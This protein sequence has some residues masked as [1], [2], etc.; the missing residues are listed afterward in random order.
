MIRTFCYELKLDGIR[1]IASMCDGKLQL[2]NKRG[3]RLLQRFPELDD[4]GAQI[5]TDCILDGEL[6]VFKDGI[7]DFTEIQKRMM[8][9][10]PF[11]IKLAAGKH[12]AVF[13]AFDILCVEDEQLMRRP[14]MER[15]Q[16][17]SEMIM[18]NTRINVSRFRRGIWRL[19]VFADGRD[20]ARR[21][22]RQT[23]DEPV[24]SGASDQRVDQVQEP[25]RR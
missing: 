15:K 25:A 13:T 17:L 12:P 11:R 16:I 4:A 1:C 2:Y 23:A 21:H 18:E 24:S 20:Q 3:Q 7:T 14:L 6:Y 5:K 22:R 10:D 8:L 9:S 19:F